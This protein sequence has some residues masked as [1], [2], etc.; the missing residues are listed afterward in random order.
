MNKFDHFT[1]IRTS[2]RLV[3]CCFQNSFITVL[4][5]TTLQLLKTIDLPFKFTAVTINETLQHALF[6]STEMHCCVSLADLT[7][8]SSKVLAS[9]FERT[10]FYEVVPSYR[11]YFACLRLFTDWFRSNEPIILYS[12]GIPDC[13]LTA[14]KQLYYQYKQRITSILH[15][16]WPTWYSASLWL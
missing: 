6:V 4:C 13:I 2:K 3:F 15:G 10:T 11:F 5:S 8:T 12:S 7:V 16:Q 14:Y 9:S 1:C